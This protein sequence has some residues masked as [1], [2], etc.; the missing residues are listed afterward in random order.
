MLRL[1]QVFKAVSSSDDSDNSGQGLCGHENQLAKGYVCICV[2]GG[3]IERNNP[4]R[5]VRYYH[6][7]LKIP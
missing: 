4:R 6:K 3:C 1:D 2:G 5:V 7:N